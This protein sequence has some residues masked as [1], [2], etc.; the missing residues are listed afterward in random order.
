MHVLDGVG[1]LYALLRGEMPVRPQSR[2]Q[3]LEAR[4]GESEYIR[5]DRAIADLAARWLRTEATG[6]P[7]PWCLY[8]GFVTPHF[9]LIAPEQYFRLYPP[10]ALPLPVQYAPEAWARHPVL[11]LKRRQQALDTPF[12]E[13]QIRNAVAAYY[14]LVSFLDEQVGLVLQA[15]REAGLE[16]ETRVIYTTDHGEML[17]EH[18]LWWKSSMYESSV[19]VPLILAGPDIP[20]GEVVR[21]NAALTDLFPTI[22]EGVGAELRPE[23]ADLPGQSLFR[24]IRD[25]ERARTVFSEYHAIFSPSGIFMV[26][27]SRYKYIHYEG[28]PPQLFDLAADPE[29]T[30]DLA[31]E[32]AHAEA[33]AACARELRA[34]C[35]PAEVDRRA[36]ADQRRRLEAAGGASAV[37]A[38]GVKIPFTPAPGGFR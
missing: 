25:G 14:G 29:E 4:A 19:A 11:E 28:Y 12:E 18:G 1:D 21:T 32:A 3:V 22:V 2:T 17:G 23:D 37:L 30:R 9:P 33:L 38:E 15:L 24:L 27:N 7:R 6:Q 20:A 16:Q 31:A 34:I 5:Y 13:R 36:K 35:D 8:V 26:R 10:E